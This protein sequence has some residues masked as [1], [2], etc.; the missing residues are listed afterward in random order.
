MNAHFSFEPT[1]VSSW[2]LNAYT[3]V[4]VPHFG[5]PAITKSKDILAFVTLV[6]DGRANRRVMFDLFLRENECSSVSDRLA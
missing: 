5:N 2:S 3:S 6:D 4:V 1:S